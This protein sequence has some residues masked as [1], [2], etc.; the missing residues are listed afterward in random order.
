[1]ADKNLR[2]KVSTRG[3]KQSSREL[4]GVDTRLKGL[5]KSAGLAA[6]AFFGARALLSGFKEAIRL[7]GIQEQAEKRLA[8]ALG[9]TSQALLKQATALQQVTTFGDEA[10]L[11]VQA[12][13][14][15]FV[16]NEDQIKKA[17]E[18]TLDMA[19]AMGMD[20]KGAGDLIAKTLGSSTNALSRYGIEV[21]G[22]VGSSERLESLT[23]NIAKLFGGQAKAQA[24]TMAGSIEQMKNAVGDAAEALGDLLAPTVMTA[25]NALKGAA[26]FA[27]KFLTGLKNL[28]EFGDVGGLDAVIKNTDQ[29]VIGYQNVNKAIASFSKKAREMGMDVKKLNKDALTDDEGRI[30]SARERL[31]FMKNAIDEEIKNRQEKQAEHNKAMKE[32]FL[33]SRVEEIEILEDIALTEGELAFQRQEAKAA[34]LA[35]GRLTT[36]ERLALQTEYNSRYLNAVK[37]TFELEAKEITDAMNRY[38]K[39][40]KDKTKLA[41][42]ETSLRTDL[43]LR[44]SSAAASIFADS[45]KKMADAGMMGME[46]AKDF[47]K[48]Q[49]LVDAYASANAAYK[50]MAGIPIVGPALA[51]AAAAAALGAGFANVK[52]IESAA[53]GFEGVVNQPTLFMTGEGNKR[54]H[55][56]VRP[57]EGPNINGPQGGITIN[58]SAPLVDETVIDSIIPAIKKAQRLDLA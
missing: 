13:I 39:V 28:K 33:Q 30:R 12:S 40:E 47:A 11:G 17:T 55:V 29:T 20:L 49:A 58:V 50:A 23:S 44:S 21:K 25:A 14:A 31:I 4:G 32:L 36:E 34:E 19:V 51:I 24:E 27:D 53:T 16:K 22:A 18:A 9:G 7:S 10:I 15:A 8:V 52:A 35:I 26:E 57:L 38:A 56:A 42:L 45:A 43:Q 6:A 37:G 1:M 2:I 48:I 3:A 54:E 46:T 41:E 5:A